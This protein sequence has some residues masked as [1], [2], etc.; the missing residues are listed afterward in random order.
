MVTGT[1]GTTARQYPYQLVHYLR[2][3]L[4]YNSPGTTVAATVGII[5][6]GAVIHEALT[7]IIV[8]TAFNDTGSDLV[9]IGTAAD[10]DLFATDLDV[11]SDGFK[12]MDEDVADVLMTA[13]TT[14]TATYAGANADASA[15]TGEVIVA[16]IPDN[17]G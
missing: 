3:T 9:D 4:A 17:D 15:G 12:A 16:F 10:G 1:A 2:K 7:G 13:D 6:N 14:I 11:S 5:P 8:I